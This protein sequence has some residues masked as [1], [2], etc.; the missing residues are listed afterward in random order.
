MNFLI[1]VVEEDFNLLR[2][3]NYK[4]NPLKHN[5]P[6]KNN[7]NNNKNNPIVIFEDYRSSHPMITRHNYV[8]ISNK[9]YK[10]IINSKI[11][12]GKIIARQNKINNKLYVD[13]ETYTNYINK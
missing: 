10:D 6:I 1:S 2:I 5:N 13:Y 9:T 7:K 4:L 3:K 8:N 11:N 12:N